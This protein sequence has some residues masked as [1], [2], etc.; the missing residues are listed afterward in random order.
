M[1]QDRRDRAIGLLQQRKQQVLRGDLLL[2]SLLGERLRLLDGL[3]G[4]LG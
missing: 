1:L 2:L 3:L 4:F